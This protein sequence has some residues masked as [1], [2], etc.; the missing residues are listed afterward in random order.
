MVEISILDKEMYT[1]KDDVY[2]FEFSEGYENREFNIK[3][4]I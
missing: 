4:I 1:I 3:R 2:N